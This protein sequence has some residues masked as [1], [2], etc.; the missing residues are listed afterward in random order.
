MQCAVTV[1]SIV[2]GKISFK[3]PT[4]QSKIYQ[5]CSGHTH[6]FCTLH[7]EIFLVSAQVVCERLSVMHKFDLVGGKCQ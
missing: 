1:R 5:S 4:L 3:L 6:S 2:T 7:I